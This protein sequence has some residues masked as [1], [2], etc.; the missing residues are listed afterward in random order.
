V[1]RAIASR[2]DAPDDVDLEIQTEVLHTLTK[3]DLNDNPFTVTRLIDAAVAR[4]LRP[5]R[6]SEERRQAKRRAL[7]WA[8]SRLPVAMQWDSDWEARFRQAARQ[9][10]A[11]LK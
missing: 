11:R 9:P 10:L 1:T 6:D 5:W 3:I 2:S 4:A 7:E 8:F